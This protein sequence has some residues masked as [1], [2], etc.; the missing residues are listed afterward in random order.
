LSFAAEGFFA[1]WGCPI[2]AAG[3]AARTLHHAVKEPVY[4]LA[5][6]E[7]L[8]RHGYK[9]S[10]GTLYPILHG[11]EERGY[12]TSSEEHSSASSDRGGSLPGR[13]TAR[14]CGLR[15]LPAADGPAHNRALPSVCEL[16]PGLRLLWT[17]VLCG[18]PG[19]VGRKC[20]AYPY[21]RLRVLIQMEGECCH[22]HK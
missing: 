20:A 14:Y 17:L 18:Y 5:M 21:N 16:L 11:L 22:L 4:G 8:A 2:N 9:L 12:L 10:A 15:P 6:I 7:E 13:G 3:D 19:V 1:Q